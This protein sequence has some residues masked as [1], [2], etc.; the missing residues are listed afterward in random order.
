MCYLYS[1]RVTKVYL[2]TTVLWVFW[3]PWVKFSRIICTS[4]WSSFNKNNHFTLVQDGFRPNYFCAHAF[5]ELTDLIRDEIDKDSNGIK[6]L[7]WS[8]GSVSEIATRVSKVISRSLLV[9]SIYIKDVAQTFQN[10][11]RIALSE[12]DTSNIKTE[13]RNCNLQK[14]LR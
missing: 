8:W 10:D 13:K 5:A 11:N 3:V 1:K 6:C 9:P 12:E 14:R 7:C 2:V 4:E